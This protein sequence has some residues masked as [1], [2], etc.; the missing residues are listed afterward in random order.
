MGECENVKINILKMRLITLLLA[1]L[2]P[3]GLFAQRGKKDV[4]YLKNG[5]VVRGTIVLQDPNKMVKLRT[6]D[7]NLWVFTNDQIDSIAH[8]ANAKAPFTTGY[9]NLTEIGVL[10]GNFSNATRAPFTLM[11][12]NSWYFPCGLATGIGVGVEFS[13]ESYLP[14]VADLRYYF[15]DKRP[16]PFFS[17]QAGY[18]FP[19]GGSY[20][21]TMYAIDDRRMSPVI[22]PGIAPNYTNDPIDAHGGFLIN[23]AIGL[24][25]QLNDNLGLTFSVGYRYMRHSYNRTGDYKIDIDYNRLSLKIGLLFK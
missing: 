24:Q 17:L 3:L 13:N 5:S 7:N 19:L 16:L 2:L 8:P 4:I 22:Y 11:N 9:F 14:V 18:S 12:I 25:T 23:P 1:V 10:A 20:S 6:T 21:Q 15:R